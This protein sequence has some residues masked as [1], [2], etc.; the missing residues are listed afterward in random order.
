MQSL[1]MNGPA[2]ESSSRDGNGEKYRDSH[3]AWNWLCY[4]KNATYRG[5]IDAGMGLVRNGPYEDPRH[6]CLLRKSRAR[7]KDNVDPDEI[8]ACNYP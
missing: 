6:D 2:F 5:D 7:G 3:L 1:T 8:T 4:R